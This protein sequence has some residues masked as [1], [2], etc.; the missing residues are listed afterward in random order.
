MYSGVLK[1]MAQVINVDRRV[2][3]IKFEATDS[4][5]RKAGKVMEKMQREDT[6]NQCD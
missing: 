1:V 6:T 2:Y 3:R 5:Q 4:I